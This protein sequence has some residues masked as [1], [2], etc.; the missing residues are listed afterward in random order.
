MLQLQPVEPSAELV[1]GAVVS[2]AAL[3]S[4]NAVS[5]AVVSAGA[6]S[7]AVAGL[8][9]AVLG[10]AVV[11][12][13]LAEGLRLATIPGAVPTLAPFVGALGL[14]AV[15]TVGV[16]LLGGRTIDL[17]DLGGADVEESVPA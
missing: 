6:V 4:C 16:S 5:S 10:G 1:V 13:S 7:G 15:V 2:A 17:A 3:L 14:S 12:G 9:G 11:E 8:A